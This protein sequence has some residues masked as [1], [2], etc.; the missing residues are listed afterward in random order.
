MFLLSCSPPPLFVSSR[1]TS[2][3]LKGSS[4]TVSSLP[5]LFPPPFPLGA[6]PLPRTQS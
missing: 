2:P 1:L 6:L 5:L 3:I 4:L